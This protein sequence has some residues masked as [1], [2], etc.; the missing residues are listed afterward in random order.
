[1]SQNLINFLEF[2]VAI[3]VS[4]ILWLLDKQRKPHLQIDLTDFSDLN[5]N[6]G[7]F[8]ILNL[9]VRNKR[10]TGIRGLFNQTA[11]QVRATL[12]FRDF[13]S[14]KEIFCDE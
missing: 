14:K 8:K 11:T 3:V 10:M 9:K 7:K 13:N 2:A 1:M 12:I 6:Q 5:L 4:L